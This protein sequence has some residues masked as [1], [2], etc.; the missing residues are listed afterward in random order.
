M[1]LETFAGKHRQICAVQGTGS[2]QDDTPR[3]SARNDLPVR[4]LASTGICMPY[5]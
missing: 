2:R 5:E 4:H 1:N 3:R